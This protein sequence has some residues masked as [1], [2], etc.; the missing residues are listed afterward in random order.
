MKLEKA[1]VDF[2]AERECDI[3]DE[4]RFEKHREWVFTL[5]QNMHRSS[6]C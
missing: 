1:E 4:G 5:S 2:M 6:W 3:R